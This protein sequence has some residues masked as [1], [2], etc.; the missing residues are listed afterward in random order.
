MA[1]VAASRAARAT[2]AAGAAA[3]RRA[4]RAA[5]AAAPSRSGVS[6]V[7]LSS[8]GANA[9]GVLGLAASRP[10]KANRALRLVTRANAD[11]GPTDKKARPRGRAR[12]AHLWQTLLSICGKLCSRASRFLARACA[13]PGAYSLA[14][15]RAL[16]RTE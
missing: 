12:G 10:A 7:A 13:P 8:K 14:C 4:A 2:G 15:L 16:R 11:I 9:T 5:C 3:P 6:S 1:T